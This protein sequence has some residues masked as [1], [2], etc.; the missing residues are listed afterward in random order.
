MDVSANFTIQNLFSLGSYQ[1]VVND[2]TNPAFIPQGEQDRIDRK[3]Y[4]YRA[5]IAQSRFAS[6]INEISPSDP[7]PELQAT[8]LLALYLS[9]P[10]NV[11]VKEQSLQE[12][13]QILSNSVPSP[14]LAVIIATIMYGEGLHEDA[15][16]IL[17]PFPQNLEW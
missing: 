13:N 17:S 2:A 3:V 4:M 5:Q 6:A 12:A 7:H 8:R 11:S 14:L 1:Q 16:R 10:S 15:L 9:N